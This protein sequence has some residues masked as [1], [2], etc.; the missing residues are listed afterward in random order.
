MTSLWSN[1]QL[2]IVMCAGAIVVVNL[3]ASLWFLSLTDPSLRDFIST[4]DAIK[5]GYSPCWICDSHRPEGT[6]HCH[7]CRCCVIN[8]SHHFNLS[9]NCVGYNNRRFYF[10]F[11]LWLFT[12]CVFVNFIN[13]DTLLSLTS[14]F[15]PKLAFSFFVPLVAWAFGMIDEDF[16]TALSAMISLCGLFYSTFRLYHELV[17]L[18]KKKLGSNWRFAWLSPFLPSSFQ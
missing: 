9:V 18:D 4:Q 14:K 15:N 7:Y 3:V 16:F 1:I 13:F 17:Q 12:G 5:Y 6:E 2:K 8:R 10:T 11:L